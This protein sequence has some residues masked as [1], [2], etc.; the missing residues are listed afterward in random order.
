MRNAIIAARTYTYPMSVA[1]TITTAEQLFRARDIG[2][3]ELLRG[4]LIMMSPTNPRH[5]QITLRIGQLLLNHIDEHSEQGTIH[6]GDPGF[7]IE[8]DPDTVRAPDVALVKKDG[9]AFKPEKGFF[10]GAPDLAI[11]VLSPGDVAGEVL[12][13]VQQWLDAGTTEVW[14]VDPDRATVTV[15]RKYRPLEVLR[16]SDQ[17]TSESLLPGFRVRVEE[18]FR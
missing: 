12:E 9:A 18:V 16:R 10:Q 13:K 14:I 3:C 1:S 4:E 8:T 6:G 7:I 15:N 11:E 2:R 5:S 17:L